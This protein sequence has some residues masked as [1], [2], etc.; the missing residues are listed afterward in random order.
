MYT[1]MDCFIGEMFLNPFGGI[2]Y[3]VGINTPIM[4]MLVSYDKD[5]GFMELIKPGMLY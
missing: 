3:T 1:D 5:I 2:C 4:I